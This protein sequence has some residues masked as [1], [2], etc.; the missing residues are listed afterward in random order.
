MAWN[1][2]ISPSLRRT[3]EDLAAPAPPHVAAGLTLPATVDPSLAWSIARALGVGADPLRA[4]FVARALAGLIDAAT[5]LDDAELGWAADA[6][7]ARGVALRGLLRAEASSGRRD[8]DGSRR[9][10]SASA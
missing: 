8:L 6:P 3:V 1:T 10:S 9:W 7:T 2:P 5:R 4:I